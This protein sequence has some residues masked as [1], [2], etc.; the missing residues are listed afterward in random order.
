MNLGQYIAMRFKFTHESKSH[1]ILE[2][3]PLIIIIIIVEVRYQNTFPASI[4]NYSNFDDFL[5]NTLSLSL[6]LSLSRSLINKI[7]LD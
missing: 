4:I 6:S 3:K 7:S 5:I 1:N 2:A